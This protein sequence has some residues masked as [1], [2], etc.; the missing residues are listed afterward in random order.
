MAVA[1]L[2]LPALPPCAGA[3]PGRHD[4]IGV[5]GFDQRLDGGLPTDLQFRDEHGNAVHL[6][7][8]LGANPLGLM[9]SYYGCSNL[10]PTQ[11]RNLAQRMAQA[12]GSGADRAQLLVVSIDPQDSPALAERAKHRYL[13]SILAPERAERWHFLSGAPAEI[14]R[15]ADSVGFSYG[16]DEATHQYAHPAGFVLV[17]PEGRISRYFFGFD[18]TARELESAFDLAAERRVASPIERLLLVCFHYDLAN[19]RYSALVLMALRVGSIATILALLAL[20]TVRLARARR[21]RTAGT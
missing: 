21:A 20:G 13:D 12:S 19:G 9:L 4:F 5:A 17:T 14:T 8:Y 11:I 6:A 1:L 15:L 7:D 18:F 10:C 3:D 16:Y 2:L